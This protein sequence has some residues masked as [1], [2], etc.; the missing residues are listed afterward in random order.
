[1]GVTAAPPSSGV[2]GAQELV[3]AAL[4]LRVGEELRA[5]QHLDGAVGL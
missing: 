5:R 4:E 1:M 2:A 3:V